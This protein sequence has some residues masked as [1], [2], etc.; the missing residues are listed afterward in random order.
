MLYPSLIGY[1]TLVPN[2]NKEVCLR[3]HIDTLSTSLRS[4]LIE[5]LY[6]QCYI[7]LYC[8]TPFTAQSLNHTMGPVTA[9]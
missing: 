4:N 2:S 6:N 9:S 3:A 8:R 1:Y 5:F 7:G